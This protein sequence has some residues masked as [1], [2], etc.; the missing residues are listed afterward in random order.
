L[1]RETGK[2]KIYV[3]PNGSNIDIFNPN[4]ITTYKIPESYVIFFGAL[5]IWQGIDTLLE[6]INDNEWPDRLKLVIIGDGTERQKIEK[7]V[8]RNSN[9]IYLGKIPY[10][11]VP[12]VI[13]N[14][15]AGLSIKNNKGN[16]SSTGLSPL[17]VYETLSC[18]VPIIVTDFPG[19]ADLVR[20]YN[21]GLVI[22]SEDSKALVRAINYLYNNPEIRAEM[23]KRGYEAIKKEHSWDKRAEETDKIL[24]QLL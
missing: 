3:V 21:C 5:A 15:I 10:K 8:L 6:A 18:G 17:K 12:G 24:R 7:I 1:Y 19:Q 22:P 13:V 23:G 9:L 20:K 16:H 4:A 11:K 14:S 2:G